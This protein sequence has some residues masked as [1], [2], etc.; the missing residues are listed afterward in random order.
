MTIIGFDTS[1][2]VTSA[3]VLRSDGRAF[4][5][6]SPAP[7]RLLGPA[8]H[9]QELLPL[10]AALMAE[11]EVGW[12]DVTGIAVGVGPGTF[13]GLRIGVSTARAL[14][15]A[16]GLGLHPVGSLD[17]LAAGAAD[18]AALDRGRSVLAL[19]DARRGQVFT[20]LYRVGDRDRFGPVVESLWQPAALYPG[21]L[22]ERVA[23]LQERPL[24]AGDWAIE[25]AAELERAGADVP[26][27]DCGFHAVDGFA[28][29]RLGMAVEP[30]GPEAV[31][32]FYIRLPDAEITKELE[33]RQRTRT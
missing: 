27:P 16:R 31:E 20:A 7:E 21:D 28:V 18:G 32:P 13:T 29:C 26:P 8:R 2:P 12:S 24:C 30:V 3:C 25:S 4:R 23:Q 5:S 22:L 11:A 17:A 6:P 19:I 10:V 33:A 1:L 14:A 9:S 15:Q